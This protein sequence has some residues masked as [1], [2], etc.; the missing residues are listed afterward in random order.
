MATVIADEHQTV[1]MYNVADAYRPATNVVAGLGLVAVCRFR[2]VLGAYLGAPNDEALEN[3]PLY[4]RGLGFYGVFRVEPSAWGEQL[5]IVA[6][7][8]DR[9]MPPRQMTHV[10][11]TMQDGTFECV[12]RDVSFE[13][14]SGRVRDVAADVLAGLAAV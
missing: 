14:R 13:T 8:K 12:A 5:A 11:V 6:L 4:E 1:L 3:H 2:L 10:I 9:A 7:K